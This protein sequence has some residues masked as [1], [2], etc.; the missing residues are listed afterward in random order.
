[1]P[2]QEYDSRSWATEAQWTW[3]WGKRPDFLDAQKNGRV[4]TFMASVYCDW[5]V[6]WPE[7]Q[8]LFGHEDEARLTEA[9]KEMLGKAVAGR[10]TKLTTWFKNRC[11]VRPTNANITSLMAAAGVTKRPTRLPQKIEVYSKKYYKQKVKSTVTAQLSELKDRLGRPLTSKEK[12]DIIKKCTA[13]AFASES[14]EVR[15]EIDTMHAALKEAVSAT[16]AALEAADETRDGRTPSQFQAAINYA[17]QVLEKVLNPLAKSMGWTFSIFGAGPVPEEGGQISSMAAHFGRNQHGHTLPQ[18][19]PDFEE[20]FI[21]PFGKF[22]KSVFPRA[23]R[24]QRRLPS[25]GNPSSETEISPSQPDHPS[26]LIPAQISPLIP[27]TTATHYPNNLEAPEVAAFTSLPAMPQVVDDPLAMAIQGRQLTPLLQDLGGPLYRFPE[28]LS[29]NVFMT[30]D[31]SGVDV[32]ELFLPS[33]PDL[34]SPSIPFANGFSPEVN[35]PPPRPPMIS[36]PPAVAVPLPGPASEA[37]TFPSTGLLTS[38][39]PPPPGV[40]LPTEPMP[41]SPASGVC[42]AGSMAHSASTVTAPSASRCEDPTVEVLPSSSRRVFDDIADSAA[43]LPIPNR[44]PDSA[45]TPALPTADSAS[46]AALAIAN[47]RPQRDRRAP[48]PRDDGWVQRSSAKAR[49]RQRKKIPVPAPGET[50]DGGLGETNG[51]E[52]GPT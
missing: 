19:T 52:P 45:S 18:A 21:R 34:A 36:P 33:I 11:R 42:S 8:A 4:S 10:R 26:D 25:L 16:D 15:D 12:L 29:P 47:G 3:L 5:F 1:M 6:E 31:F 32:G 41:E 39:P 27:D 38:T 43:N 46:T 44:A 35:T 17:P 30:P 20:Q 28:A 14:Q 40:A 23:V 9:E 24:E 49:A 7:I 50:N 2:G 48:R 37:P 13:S 51:G 22:A